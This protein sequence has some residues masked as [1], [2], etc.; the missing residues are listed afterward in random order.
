MNI[1]IVGSRNFSD[2]GYLKE[3][4]DSFLEDKNL[5]DILIVSGGA[6]GA[7]QLAEKYANEKNI[8]T[9]IFLP[10]WKQFGRSAGFIRNADII[11]NSDT[12]IAFWDGESNGTK[13]SIDLGRKKDKKIIIW[14]YKK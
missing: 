12:V 3:K 13:N 11:K 6:K 1:A 9:M 2:Y 10:D 7:D 4:L 14:E 5:N 8:S